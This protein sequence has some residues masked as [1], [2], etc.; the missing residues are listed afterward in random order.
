LRLPGGGGKLEQLIPSERRG[1]VARDLTITVP[2]RPGAGAELCEAVA[3]AGINIEGFCVFPH[4]GEKWG[5]VHLLVEDAEAARKAIEGA[6]IEIAADRDVLLVELE[7][8]PGALA[9][10]LRQFADRDVNVDLGYITADGRVVI[11]TDDMH[12]ARVGV[13]VLNVRHRP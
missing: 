4:R 8:R 3:G 6:G 11:G 9:E 5:V 7:N 2:D 1:E 13:N 12:E 10:L